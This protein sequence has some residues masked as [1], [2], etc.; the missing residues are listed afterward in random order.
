MIQIRN[1]IVIYPSTPVNITAN[2]G[3]DLEIS[4]KGMKVITGP[5]G[6][7]KST[8]FKV[9]SGELN[10]NAG[11]F[12]L[13]G[14]LISKKDVSKVLR[15]S[16]AYAKQDFALNLEWSG[17]RH[18]DNSKEVN[19]ALLSKLLEDLEIAECW[20]LPIAELTRDKRQLVGLTLTLL[21]K[22]PILLLDEPTKYL[23][24]KSRIQLLTVIKKISKSKSV[25]I[26]THDPF[27]TTR[28]KE[29]VHIQEGRVV[30]NGTRNSSDS[31]GWR[32]SGLLQKPKSLKKL[33]KHKN[34]EQCDELSKFMEK[35]INSSE[36][37]RLFDPEL[38]TYDEVSPSELFINQKIKL[39]TELQPHADQRIRTLSGG[40]RSWTYLYLHLSKKPKEIF[41]LYPT[42]N[43]DQSNQELLQKMV[44]EL[45]NRGSKITIFDID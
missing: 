34:I 33:K 2:R 43:L 44:I 32:F 14:S 31:Y 42:L 17:S 22:K 35:L 30:Q 16:I 19:S 1:L 12:R 26:A 21:S 11:E 41:L 29:A 10:P 40:E 9:L 3:I 20:D 28:R 6:S 24:E 5:N 15:E 25:L 4:E 23:N 39:P 37:F 38:I 36:E 8:L 7:G 18:L 27:W 45:A 13:H